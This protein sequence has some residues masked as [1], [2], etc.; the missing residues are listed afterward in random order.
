MSK[1]RHNLPQLGDRLFMTEGGLETTLIFHNGIDLPYFASF[2]L[3][4]DAAGTAVLE[5]YYKHFA[6]MA[7]ERGIGAV[8]EAPTWRANPDWAAKLGYSASMLA[9]ANRKAISL[10]LRVR[11]AYETSASPIVI[12]GNLGPR[13]DGYRADAR[14]TAAE[15][16][17]YHHAQIDTFARTDADMIAAFTMNYVDEAVGIV[18]AAKDCD[19]PVA[20]SFT[21]E[22]DG[23]LPSG[24]TLRDAIER[25]DA[26]TGGYPV[27]YM[28]NC[29]HP[30]HFD[31]VLHEEGG[32]R[33]RLRG[34]RA[35]ASRRSHAELDEASDL[36][37]GNP[38]EL[39]M[40]YRSLRSALPGLVVV[41]G[42]CG[43]DHRHVDAVC[44]SMA[45]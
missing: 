33:Q 24:D 43:T 4:K 11:A 42:C 36:D 10:L 21:L 44:R 17:A 20:I 41:G 45:A 16:L 25:T 29:A 3:L 6:A 30:T 1:Y 9:E 26:R 32:W 34:L 19:M 40:Q 35:N 31:T 27:Y 39:A 22:T 14:M 15:A 38:Q 8:L 28:I 5:D 13:G 18:L 7:V 37:D 2:D 23:R 12:S